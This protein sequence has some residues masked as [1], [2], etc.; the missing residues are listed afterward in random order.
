MTL[1][2]CP[3]CKNPAQLVTGRDVYPLREDLRFLKI[4]QCGPCDARVGCHKDTKIPK[5]TLANTEL[6]H[7]RIQ[8]HKLFDPMWKK[9]AKSR[10]E[11]YIWLSKKLGIPPKKCHIGNF[12]KYMCER[13]IKILDHD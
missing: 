2:I 11:A 4:W 1:V 6:R 13:V 10:K 3:Y 9:G 5:G 8:A 7:C 12:N